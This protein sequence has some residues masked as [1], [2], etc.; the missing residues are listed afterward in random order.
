MMNRWLFARKFASASAYQQMNRERLA[1]KNKSVM[2]YSASVMITFLGLTYAAVPLYQV[3]CTNT[4]LDG[5]PV[6]S[7]TSDPK[8]LVP[9]SGHRPITISFDASV[10]DSMR[11]KFHPITRKMSLVPGET[12]LAFYSAEN[13][14]DKDIVGISTYSVGMSAW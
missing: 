8:K 7:Q 10:S 11:W 3:L 13:T 4:G 1:D 6:T 2:F 14:S 12:A 5:T 9:V